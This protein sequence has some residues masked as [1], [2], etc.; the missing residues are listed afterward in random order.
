MAGPPIAIVENAAAAL[1]MKTFVP[2]ISVI[3]CT[4]NGEN[5]LP[6]TLSAL[7]AAA[8]HATGFCQILVV[9]NASYDRTPDIIATVMRT[10]RVPIMALRESR[11]GLSHA[12]NCGITSADTEI[13]AFTDDDV[14]VAEDWIRMIETVFTDQTIAAAGG[15]IQPEA[16]RVLPRWL[17]PDLY[18][19]FALIDYGDT[20]KHMQTADIWGANI[21]FREDCFTRHG[22]FD[23]QLGRRGQR[24][25]SG[26]ETEFVDRLLK[27][28]ET[29]LYDPRL[30]VEHR[31][32]PERLTKP[33]LCRSTRDLGEQDYYFST[34]EFRSFFGLPLWTLNVVLRNF[35]ALLNPRNRNE[36]VRLDLRL[37]RHHAIGFARGA[38]RLRRRRR[39]I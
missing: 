35:L 22:L 4:H 37:K 26:E 12:R 17:T 15:K 31:L 16:G 27:A 38:W 11:L 32:A 33:Y 39:T 6:T 23:T 14:T 20:V 5:R 13:I 24:L 2:G 36:R 34:R 1:P 19:H 10:S 29:V 21:V 28:G 9:D 30:R 8:A 3:V 25:Y 7:A 18:H